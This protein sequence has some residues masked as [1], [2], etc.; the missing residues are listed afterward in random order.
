M[1]LCGEEVSRPSAALC[2]LLY[3]DLDP[4]AIAGRLFTVIHGDISRCVP[5]CAQ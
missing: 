2:N 1:E 3:L 5:N 4:D